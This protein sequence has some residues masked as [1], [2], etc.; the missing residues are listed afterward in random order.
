MEKRTLGS[1]IYVAIIQTDG[2]RSRVEQMFRGFSKASF[3]FGGMTF[4][5]L[6]DI[7]TVT[8]VRGNHLAITHIDEPVDIENSSGVAFRVAVFPTEP[9]AIAFLAKPVETSVAA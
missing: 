1:V 6:G 8:G 2:A 7:L 4:S 9:M 5:W 3:F